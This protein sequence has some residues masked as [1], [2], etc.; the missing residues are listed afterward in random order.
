MHPHNDDDDGGLRVVPMTKDD[1]LKET[2]YDVIHG[3]KRYKLKI[4]AC[5]HGFKLMYQSRVKKIDYTPGPLKGMV[6]PDELAYLTVA[7]GHV[8]EMGPW[9]WIRFWS[10]ERKIFHQVRMLKA[11]FERA[12]SR[13]DI[14]L[15]IQKSIEC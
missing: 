5:D 12:L 11:D 4:D 14:A 7:E 15:S 10:M 2:K 9:D 1:D 3:G 6:A 13:Q 8:H